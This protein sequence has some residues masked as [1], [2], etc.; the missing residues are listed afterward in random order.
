[1]DNKI[2]NAYPYWLIAWSPFGICM[3]TC[4]LVACLSNFI[5]TRW[6]PCGISWC[7]NI[8]R[9]KLCLRSCRV[10]QIPT[11]LRLCCESPSTYEDDYLVLVFIKYLG[12]FP[13][14]VLCVGLKLAAFRDFPVWRFVIM[15]LYVYWAWMIMDAVIMFFKLLKHDSCRKKGMTLLIIGVFAFIFA[16]YTVSFGF[17]TAKADGQAFLEKVPYSALF[18]GIFA[19]H[20]VF[21]FGL[22]FFKF[23]FSVFDKDELCYCYDCC[24]VV[25]EFVYYFGLM[26]LACCIFFPFTAT[27]IMLCVKLDAGAY[28]YDVLLFVYTF[29]PMSGLYGLVIIVV[30]VGVLCYFGCFG[31]IWLLECCNCNCR[32][33]DRCMDDIFDCAEDVFCNCRPRCWRC[34]DDCCCCCC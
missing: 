20:L 12:W 6:W 13:I 32:C 2:P 16:G 22:G 27:Y 7:Y 4:V 19:S 11:F 29:L 24:E 9:T 17:I 33:L 23:F 31:C 3:N 10:K 21:L 28:V 8:L 18:S 14:G 26:T 15:P 1:M 5:A 30:V 34:C 25:L